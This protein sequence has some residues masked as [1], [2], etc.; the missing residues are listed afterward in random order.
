MEEYYQI[1]INITSYLVTWNLKYLVMLT[2][3]NQYQL[4]LVSTSKYQIISTNMVIANIKQFQLVLAHIS[5]CLLMLAHINQLLVL[6]FGASAT[7]RAHFPH[8]CAELVEKCRKYTQN[9][10]KVR[11]TVKRWII[12]YCITISYNV[13]Y[14]TLLSCN[15]RCVASCGITSYDN[16]L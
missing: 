13:L 10:G 12:L 4:T 16:I 11:K 5:Q 6:I 1:S 2:N 9:Q 7:Q 14:Y 3:V 15:I 8:L